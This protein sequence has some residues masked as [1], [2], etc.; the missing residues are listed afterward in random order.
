VTAE[1]RILTPER[2]IPHDPDARSEGFQQA[3]HKGAAA[4]IVGA[5]KEAQR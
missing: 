5:G 1:R 2:P 4:A 3:V